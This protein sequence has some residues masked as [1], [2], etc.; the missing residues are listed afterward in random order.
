VKIDVSVPV[1]E[2]ID[3]LS[4]LLIKSKRISDPS[5]LK[6][7]ELE[8]GLLEDA[9]RIVPYEDYL[10]A[11]VALNS[12]MWDCNEIRKHK[13]TIGDFDEQYFR[14][15]ISESQL[16]D[17]RYLIKQAIDEEFNSTLREQKSYEGYRH[18]N[19]P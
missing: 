11:L 15:T 7:I 17:K 10:D 1:S 19:H 13:I 5:Q 3:K 8:I 2:A 16:N 14:L 6:Y 9:L 4:I 12:E 18:N